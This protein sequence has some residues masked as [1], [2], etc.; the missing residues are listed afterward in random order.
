MP[1]KSPTLPELIAR[2]EGN[3]QQRLKGSATG[4]KESPGVLARA[5]AGLD[6]GL[7]EHISGHIARLSPVMRMKLN[8]SNIASSGVFAASSRRRQAT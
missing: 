6:A 4:N 2:A 7:H 5:Q 8:C 3:I 1:Y